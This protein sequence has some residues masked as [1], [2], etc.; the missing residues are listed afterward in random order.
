MA[1]AQTHDGPVA[2]SP[3][4]V[5]GIR[6]LNDILTGKES[7]DQTKYYLSDSKGARIE[8]P[9]SIFRVLASVVRE[10]ASGRSVMV[11]HYDHELTTQQAAEILNVSRPFLIS[12][13]EKKQIPYHMAGT[14]R[15]I[16]MGDLLDFRRCRDKSRQDLLLELQKVSES[17]GLYDEEGSAE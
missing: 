4:E 7:E 9:R 12:L 6:S 10:M 13:L 16:R 5:P 11:L 14:H 2:A 17:L 3:E 15:R 8:L 1:S